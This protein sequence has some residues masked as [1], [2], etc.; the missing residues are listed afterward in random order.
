MMFFG[1]GMLLF[2][3]LV[4]GVIVAALGG[5]GVLSGRLRTDGDETASTRAKPEEILQ[6][7]Y[8][9][10][11]ISREEYEQMRATLKS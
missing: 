7:R 5:L 9:R 10:G 1:G 2:W 4:I 3:L 6:T 8:A 11:E